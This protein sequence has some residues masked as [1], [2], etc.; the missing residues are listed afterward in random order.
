MLD[1]TLNHIDLTDS[2]SDVRLAQQGDVQAFERLY[3]DHIGRVYA[4]CLR[5][6]GNPGRAEE[7]AQDAFVRAWEK[8]G[9]FRGNSAFA[10]WLYRLAVNVVYTAYRSDRRRDERVSS[11]DDMEALGT[12]APPDKPRERM[13]LEAAIAT[14]PSGA[15][16][17]FVLHDMEGFQHN[18]IAEMEGIAIGTSKAQLHRARRMLQEVLS[19]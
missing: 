19:S 15:R 18:E 16:R 9:T 14:L 1:K 3:R 17:I 4:L 12:P 11:F 5:L 13:D 7:L 10:T 6:S 8:L 2:H